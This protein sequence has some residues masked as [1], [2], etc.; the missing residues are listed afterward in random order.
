MLRP[1]LGGLD[2]DHKPKERWLLERQLG[3]LRAFENTLDEVCHVTL[4][5][6]HIWTA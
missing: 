2:V 1:R 3:G 6:A 5:L 4:E